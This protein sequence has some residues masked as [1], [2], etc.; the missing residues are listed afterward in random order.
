[1]SSLLFGGFDCALEVLNIVESVEDTDDVDTVSDAFLY[2]ILENVVSI[3]AVAEHILTSE[4]HLEL[5]VGA[6][7]ADCAEPLPRVLV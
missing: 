6:V 5:C 3:V 1:M 7:L 2:K 4:K